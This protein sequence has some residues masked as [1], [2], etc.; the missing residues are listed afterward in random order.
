MLLIV[1]NREDLTAD[2]LILEL[3]RRAVDF[4][5][6]NTEDY[7]HDIPVAW[8]PAAGATITVRGRLIRAADVTATWWRR[9]VRPRLAPGLDPASEAW[10]AREAAEALQAFWHAVGGEWVSHPDSIRRA[11]SKPRQLIDAA[12]LG[13]DV[14]DTVITNERGALADLCNRAPD[15]VVCKPLTH[16][17]VTDGPDGRLFFTRLITDDM[18]LTL[19]TDPF[20][21]QARI[22]KAYD[23]RVTVVGDELFATRIDSQAAAGAAVD[24]R[25]GRPGELRH[26]PEEL[27][28]DLRD[29]CC[30]LTRH[31]GLRFGAIDLARRPDGGYTFFEINPNGQWAWIEQRTGVPLR[32]RLADMLTRSR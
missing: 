24:W 26:S 8:T 32:A 12:E 29:L 18:P 13:F 2:W 3:E 11:S 10:A 28:D 31:Y 16:G 17:R 14:P 25:R 20:L 27:P 22:P 5:R 6:F 4:V 1:T 30:R 21:F 15:G 23:V 9:P 19:A 7:P